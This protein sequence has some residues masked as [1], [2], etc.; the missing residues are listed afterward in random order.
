MD[1]PKVRVKIGLDGTVTAHAVAFADHNV[2]GVEVLQ[3]DAG[4][5]T[6]RVSEIELVD[7]GEGGRHE[8][9]LPAEKV[10]GDNLNVMVMITISRMDGEHDRLL[11][12][13]SR[14]MICL[15]SADLM[16]AEE[17]GATE[18]NTEDVAE[19]YRQLV[20]KT[21]Y[22]T[23]GAE[24]AMAEISAKYEEGPAWW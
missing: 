21:V 20:C 24:A 18:V 14:G 13:R 6:P 12:N 16:H 17:T 15:H 10:K 1:Y 8:A 11:S 5:G 2:I 22:D 4:T 19:A 7:D 9:P 23:P 3:H